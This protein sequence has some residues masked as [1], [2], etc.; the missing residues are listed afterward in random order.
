[1][2]R[3]RLPI[4]ELATPNT[5]NSFLDTSFF[6]CSNSTHLGLGLG[7]QKKSKRLSYKGCA[8]NWV[9]F[10]AKNQLF[11]EI[12]F[13]LTLAYFTENRRNG[14]SLAIMQSLDLSIRGLYLLGRDTLDP[15]CKA[16]IL[17]RK[18]MISALEGCISPVGDILQM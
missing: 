14:R 3:C 4:R 12:A 16:S 9:V 15:A 11:A 7:N 2:P 1:M 8:A 18:A 10:R 5:L 6:V 13:S 17:A